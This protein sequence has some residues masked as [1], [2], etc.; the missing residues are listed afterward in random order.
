MGEQ[1]CAVLGCHYLTN[2]KWQKCD[3]PGGHDL[4]PC[5]LDEADHLCPHT[6]LCPPWC[7]D[8]EARL[9]HRY[10]GAE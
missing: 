4:V 3:D 2:G 7:G 5:G 8:D 1:R 10:E 9:G 6:G